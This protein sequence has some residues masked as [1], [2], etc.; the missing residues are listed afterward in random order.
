[1]QLAKAY[2]GRVYIM[3]YYVKKVPN[4]VNLSTDNTDN[5]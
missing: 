5:I 2:C 4:I 1:M 3:Q